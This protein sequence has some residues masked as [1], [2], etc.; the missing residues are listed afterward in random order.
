MPLDVN[1]YSTL[2]VMITPALFMTANGSLIISTSN[3]M[4]RV[5]DRIRVLNDL[6]DALC[7]GATD[8]DLV[9]ERLA[10]VADQLHHLE[11]RSDRVR[12]A[13]SMLYLAFGCFVGTSLMLALD[14][15]FGNRL[16]AIPTLMAVCGVS[17]LL[18]ASINLVR[19]ARRALL[20]NRLEVRFYRDLNAKRQAAASCGM[21]RT[22]SAT[23]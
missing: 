22:S 3:R 8:L 15:L 12:Y 6:R 20:T 11:W 17:L 4:S 13:L 19:E 10:H 1:S 18:G 23:A 2:S 5:V 16:V 9:P 14:V 21:P 7:R